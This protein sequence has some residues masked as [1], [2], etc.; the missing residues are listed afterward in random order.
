MTGDEVPRRSGIQCGE[1][2]RSGIGHEKLHPMF[3]YRGNG[4]HLVET[5]GR[6]EVTKVTLTTFRDNTDVLWVE[7]GNGSGSRKCEGVHIECFR[8]ELLEDCVFRVGT[9]DKCPSD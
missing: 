9:S 6:V 4:V 7:K 8:G 3:L 1:G 2:S 5:S